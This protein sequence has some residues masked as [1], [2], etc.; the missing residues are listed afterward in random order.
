MTGGAAALGAGTGATAAGPAALDAR[1]M[2]TRKGFGLDAVISATPGETIAIMGPSGAGKSTLLS[3]IAGLVRLS[4]GYVRVAG[5]VVSGRVDAGG[6]ARSRGMSVPPNK[7]GVVLLGQDARLFPHM[8]ARDNVAF[9]LRTHGVARDIAANQAD[10]LLWRVGLPGLGGQRPAGLSGGQ[11][12]RVALARALA[13]QP[14]L[15]LLDEPLTS[16]DPV[17]AAGIRAV[18]A[19][20]R[21][22]ITTVLVTHDAV[23]AAALASRVLVLEDGRVSQDA[24]ARE[25]FA[26][27]ATAFAASLAGLNRVVGQGVRG[28]W[29]D[30]DRRVVLPGATAAS[31]PDGG[32]LAAVFRPSAVSVSRVDVPSWTAALRVERERARV[33]GEWLTRIERLEQ[34]PSGVRVHT[35]TPAVVA[36]VPVEDVAEL[37]LAP[38]VPVR[39]RVAAENVRL[40]AI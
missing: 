28:A 12:Q 33:P 7:R 34:T 30:D 2:V 18:I 27:P 9:A 10:E 32:G 39:L 16:L 37:G 8:T 40:L 36:E 19:E 5:R 13:A 23:D 38:G 20:L 6:S 14:Q 15:L 35:A 22:G 26:R 21:V 25:V 31:V 17:T 29:T 24:P 3:A 11:Q 4:G 1:V